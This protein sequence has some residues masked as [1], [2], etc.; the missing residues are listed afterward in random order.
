MDAIRKVMRRSHLC[1]IERIRWK[2]PLEKKIKEKRFAVLGS[3]RVWLWY[4]AKLDMNLVFIHVYMSRLLYYKSF[5]S[6][7]L[8]NREKEIYNIWRISTLIRR[9]RNIWLCISDLKSITAYFIRHF[10]LPINNFTIAINQNFGFSPAPFNFKNK[11]M[12]FRFKDTFFFET[13]ILI[14]LCK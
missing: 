6:S 1:L 5:R 3:I 13:V 11:I 8:D 12:Y 9:Y 4:H 7:N 10:D 14:H 2:S